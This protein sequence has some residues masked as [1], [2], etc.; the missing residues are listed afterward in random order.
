MWAEL[1]DLGYSEIRSGIE[2]KGLASGDVRAAVVAYNNGTPAVLCYPVTSRPQD[3]THREAA[4][5]QAIAMDPKHPP[6]Y[7]W[8]SDGRDDYFF[9]TERNVALSALPRAADS[10]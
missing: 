8:V 10:A 3:A 9:D 2:V 6:R 5:A 7:V 4:H 1:H